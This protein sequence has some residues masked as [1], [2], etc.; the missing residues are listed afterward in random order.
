[1]PRYVIERDFGDVG[2]DEI[3]EVAARSKVTGA[4][5]FPDIEWEHSHVVSDAN[6]GTI[7]SFCVYSAPTAARLK[8]HAD[9]VGGHEVTRVYEIIG[10]VTPDEVIV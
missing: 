1:M 9:A 6:S 2:D 7:K 5:Q 4:E 3:Q 8:E 10:D